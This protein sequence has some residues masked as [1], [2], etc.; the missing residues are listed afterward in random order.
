MKKAMIIIAT[1]AVLLVLI[2]AGTNRAVDGMKGYRAPMFRIE[3]NDSTVALDQ[4]KGQWVLLQFWKSSDASSRI[5]VKQYTDM[6]SKLDSLT[7]ER[8]QHLAVNMD[9]NERLFNEVVRRDGLSAESQFHASG[10]R[11]E[12]LIADYHLKSG[13]HAYLIDP[14]GKIVAK[15]P[16]EE[17]MIRLSQKRETTKKD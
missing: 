5:A 8:F 15:N 14:S 17:E 10:S 16:S 4:L 3:N 9:R 1:F 12:K 13:M 6:E 7:T 11:A 2:T